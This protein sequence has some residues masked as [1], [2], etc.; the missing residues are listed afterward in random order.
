M[1]LIA[2]EKQGH[3]NTFKHEY[4]PSLAYCRAVVT[5]NDV[6]GT[7]AIGT[8]V[9]KVTA[10]GKFKKCVQTAS[11]G[12][13][14]AAGIVMVEKTVAAAADTPVL[15]MTR[16]PA[17]VNKAGLVLDASYDLA[18]EKNAIY[19]NLEALGIEVL[20]AI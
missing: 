2:T 7:L 5:V 10:T 16:G 12:S 3:S 13:Q 20:N 11:D 1:A 4:E 18:A 8:V 6:A 17:A 15:V 9:G 14:N 19:A